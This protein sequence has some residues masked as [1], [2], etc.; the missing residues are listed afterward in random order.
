[1]IIFF[2][3]HFND[4]DHM[5]PVVWK[6][7][8]DNHPV[9]V[10]CMNPDY[11]IETDFRLQF[12]RTL[13]IPVAHISQAFDLNRDPLYKFLSFLTQKGANANRKLAFQDQ[14]NPTGSFQVFN[15][16]VG[17]LGKKAFKLQN[18]IYFNFRWA[19]AV[20]IKT[21]AQ[22]ICFDEVMPHF[23]VVD[24]FLRAA[25][26]LSIPTISLPHGIQLFTSAYARPKST[27]SRRVAK[28]GRFD[29][30]VA[31]NQLKKEFLIN[32]GIDE[33][34][35]Q[36]LGSAR[37][38]HEWLEQYHKILPGKIK[39]VGNRVGKLKVVLMP[40]RPHSN[41]D[42]E[43]T[44]GTCAM[45]AELDPVHAVVK[46]HTRF[47]G[48]QDLFA[49]TPLTDV[50]EI[51]SAE[52]LEWADVLLIV[53]SSLILEAHS[54]GKPALYLKYLHPNTTLFEEM[55]ACWTIHDE[56][57]LKEALLILSADKTK[58][59]YTRDKVD[60]FL[61]EVVY[62]GDRNRDVLK[63]FENLLLGGSAARQI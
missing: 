8:L 26:T 17:F 13:D 28:F 12:L 37:Y 46:P 24:I 48:Y 29:F 22:A 62:A 45:L 31:P 58:V 23:Y 27:D 3:R 9:T 49:N 39:A 47:K 1:M 54:L 21:K 10:C 35:V 42:I 36:V 34:K 50:S 20:L 40:S 60:D 43:R 52:L 4:I 30:I 63:D 14:D 7:K 38:C 2:V 44:L 15:K 51:P 19:R 33:H 56:T 32:A 59:P 53:A 16:L 18:K 5:V 61:A 55:G 41:L 57:E 25:K 6:L 11:D